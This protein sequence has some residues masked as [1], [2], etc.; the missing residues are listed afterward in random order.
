MWEVKTCQ[1]GAVT[2]ALRFLFKPC[3]FMS[4]VIQRYSIVGIYIKIYLNISSAFSWLLCKT[5]TGTMNSQHCYVSVGVCDT[6]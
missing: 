6:V 4:T 3:I 2:S 5:E 1:C